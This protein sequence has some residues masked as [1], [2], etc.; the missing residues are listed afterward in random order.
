[1]AGLLALAQ[2]AV[3]MPGNAISSSMGQAYYGE[4]SKM[5]L[6][7]TKGLRSLYIRT[8]KLLTVISIPL[9]GMPTL[10]APF[11]FGLI[12][13]E[14]WVEA[15]WFCWP[16]GLM[17][18]VNYTITPVS[19]LSTYGYNH[20]QLSWDVMRTASVMGGFYAIL[21]YNLSPFQVS[22]IYAIIMIIMFCFLY[23]LNIIA[24]NKFSSKT[25]V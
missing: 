11:V 7:R 8:F 13:G 3:V 22:V 12:F 17:E 1:L 5:A 10:L 25:D 24:I 16:L 21:Y 19:Y 15:G 9:I 18:M 20:W 4:I 2:F 23:F 6:E 14:A